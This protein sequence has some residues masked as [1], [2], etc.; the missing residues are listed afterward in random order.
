MITRRIFI[1]WTAGFALFAGATVRA[2]SADKTQQWIEI[3]QSQ[4]STFEKARACQQLG[5]SGNEQAVP[6]LAGR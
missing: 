3:L 5:E 6:A 1:L 4:S 2:A